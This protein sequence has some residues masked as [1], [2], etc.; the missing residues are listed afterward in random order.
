[1]STDFSRNIL[2]ISSFLENQ[3]D[4][5]FF[6]GMTQFSKGAHRGMEVF[7]ALEVYQQSHYRK[8]NVEG[9]WEYRYC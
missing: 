3:E 6:N 8:P 9:R 5:G 4:P 1:M 7:A 2:G